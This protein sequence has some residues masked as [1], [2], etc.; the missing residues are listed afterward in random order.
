MK[1]IFILFALLICKISSG[2]II[3]TYSPDSSSLSILLTGQIVDSK[4]NN[5]S[6]NL[7]GKWIF[8]KR[9]SLNIQIRGV[10]ENKETISSNDSTHIWVLFFGNPEIKKITSNFPFILTRRVS[11]KSFLDNSKIKISINNLVKNRRL[12]VSINSIDISTNN[13]SY[14]QYRNNG[15]PIHEK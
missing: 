9:D 13:F 15:L 7:N 5:F 2:Q 3:Y 12:Q 14:K 8:L 1:S 6:L 11:M 4:H 10:L